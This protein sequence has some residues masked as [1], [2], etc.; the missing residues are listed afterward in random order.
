MTDNGL[1]PLAVQKPI[2]P[3]ANDPAIIPVMAVLHV[4]VSRAFSLK[5]WF[6]G[7]SG[8]I[9][10]HFYV[11]WSGKVEQY[12]SVKVE[13]D[14]QYQGNSWLV[15]AD[16]PAGVMRL[17]GVSIETAG[18]ANG[19]WNSAQ[20]ASIQALLL[21]L[22]KTHGIPLQPVLQANP[23]SLSTGG[24]SYHTRFASWSNVKGKT[25]PGPKRVM[26]FVQVIRPWMHDI[27]AC[28]HCPVHCPKEH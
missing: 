28:L 16:K 17:G 18:F 23:H 6:S 19:K 13:A 14:A 9:E 20:L 22:H 2:P 21:W 7:P 24:V 4:A 26:Q 12:R 8:G 25:C 3:G 11:R 10:S 15:P 1:Y 5:G 27:T